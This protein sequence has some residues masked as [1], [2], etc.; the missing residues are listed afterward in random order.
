MVAGLRVTK[1]FSPNESEY[2]ICFSFISK[3]FLFTLVELFVILRKKYMCNNVLVYSIL[4][5]LFISVGSLY[6]IYELGLLIM[7]DGVLYESILP[8][9]CEYEDMRKF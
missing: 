1:L 8:C 9:L 2:N 6:A 7:F 3:G 5:C 4:G